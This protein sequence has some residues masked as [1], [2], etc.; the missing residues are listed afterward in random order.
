MADGMAGGMAGIARDAVDT[1]III[2]STKSNRGIQSW[3]DLAISY[4]S[5]PTS[6][7]IDPDNNRYMNRI[8]DVMMG[9][10]L[11]SLPTMMNIH[12]VMDLHANNEKSNTM[13]GFILDNKVIFCTLKW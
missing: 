10:V 11:S 5:T 8:T 9:C 1:D 2:E 13:M 4:M 3:K 6:E 12:P 7:N